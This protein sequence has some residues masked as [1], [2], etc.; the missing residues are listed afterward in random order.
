MMKLSSSLID[1]QTCADETSKQI[2]VCR[3]SSLSRRAAS[4]KRFSIFI[5]SDS[6]E[7]LVSTFLYVFLSYN[8]CHLMFS[9][10]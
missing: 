1:I 3:Q 2:T 8:C 6:T 9:F 5:A 7:C 10:C 4:L